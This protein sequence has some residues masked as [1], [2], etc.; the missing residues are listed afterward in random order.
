MAKTR[1]HGSHRTPLMA[2]ARYPHQHANRPISHQCV[3]NQRAV[4]CA[5]LKC[6]NR[7]ALSGCRALS[8][9][10]RHFS[11]FARRRQEDS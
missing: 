6:D 2:Q 4:P 11:M 5:V 7:V 10:S 3:V 1:S 8:L 9:R